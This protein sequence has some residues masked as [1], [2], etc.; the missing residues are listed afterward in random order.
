M[1]A[2]M[3]D[4]LNGEPPDDRFDELANNLQR[5]TI[6]EYGI[7]FLFADNAIQEARADLGRP[8]PQNANESD[9]PLTAALQ[10]WAG[11]TATATHGEPFFEYKYHN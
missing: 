3:L 2:G 5:L 1:A 7:L 10:Q 6:E 11:K 8:A 4:V 9:H